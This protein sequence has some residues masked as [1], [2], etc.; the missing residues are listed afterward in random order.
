MTII[1]AHFTLI[2]GEPNVNTLAVEDC[3]KVDLYRYVESV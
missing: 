2:A 1:I 3:D